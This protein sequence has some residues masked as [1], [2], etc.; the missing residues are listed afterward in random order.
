MHVTAPSLPLLPPPRHGSNAPWKRWRRRKEA[1]EP[2]RPHQRHPRVK[3]SRKTKRPPTATAAKQQKKPSFESSL[4]SDSPSDKDTGVAE[5]EVPGRRQLRESASSPAGIANAAGVSSSAA[6]TS[7][8]TTLENP[9]A[10]AVVEREKS[11]SPRARRRLEQ[12]K[13]LDQEVADSEGGGGG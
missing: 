7:A 13:E 1:G 12:A 5:P 9:A 11:D 6:S 3:V 2:L 10:A 8:T 4:A